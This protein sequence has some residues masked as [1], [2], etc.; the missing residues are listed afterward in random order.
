MLR[1]EV[2]NFNVVLGNNTIDMLGNFEI[3]VGIWWK[4]NACHPLKAN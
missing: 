2:E 4:D 3:Q 1:I